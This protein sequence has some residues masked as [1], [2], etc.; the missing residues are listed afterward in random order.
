[1]ETTSMATKKRAAGKAKAAAPS[2]D[3]PREYI[4]VRLSSA[5][6][7]ELDALAEQLAAA[8]PGLTLTRS[9]ALRAAVK[10]GLAVFRKRR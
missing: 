5:D 9:D 3:G 2:E 6:V 8:V 7:A 4:A 1:M 10:E